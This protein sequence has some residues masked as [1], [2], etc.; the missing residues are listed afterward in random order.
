MAN[1][2]MSLAVVFS[3]D[4]EALSPSPRRRTW[5][6]ASPSTCQ[7]VPVA[8]VHDELVEC[9]GHRGTRRSGTRGC[10]LVGSRQAPG[11]APPFPTPRQVSALVLA[12]RP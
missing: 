3:D 8:E 9:V 10:T 1:G 12:A 2:A 5:L 7:D 4:R 6:A 11:V